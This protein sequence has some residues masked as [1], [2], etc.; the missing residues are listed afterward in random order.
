MLIDDCKLCR[1]ADLLGGR[2]A[3]QRDLDHLDQWAGA[4]GMRF[5]K[6]KCQVL[7]FGENNLMQHY[8]LEA[9]TGR[10]SSRKGPGDAEHE[11]ACTQVAKKTNDI[12][13][14]GQQDQG[15][16]WTHVKYCVQ[17]WACHYKK[18]IE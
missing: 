1:N 9:V 18:D 13:A 2:K 4:S 11:S 6:I 15:S 14:C 8:R 10:G 12:L 5:N 3:L 17:F 16:D 7:H